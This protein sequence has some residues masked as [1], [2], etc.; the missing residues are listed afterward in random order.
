MV[1]FLGLELY[2]LFDIRFKDLS[3]RTANYRDIV[4]MYWVWLDI[5]VEGI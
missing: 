4:L 3:I 5:G 1:R 2:L